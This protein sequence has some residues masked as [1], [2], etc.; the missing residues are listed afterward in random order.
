MS[1][2]ACSAAVERSVKKLKGI[3]RIEVSLLT[4]S[5]T[6]DYDP[7]AVTPGT[8][9]EAV[10]NAGYGATVVG[11][12]ETKK[13]PS[14]TDDGLRDMRVRLIASFAFLIPLMYVA[15]GHMLSLPI[16]PF[17]AGESNGVAFAL[18]QLLLTLPIMYLN[19]KYY[20]VGFR[21]LFKLSPNMDTLVATGSL[22]AILYGVYSIYAISYAVANNDSDT[23]SS[24]L[25]N[26]YFESGA[27]ILT[28][29]TLGKYFEARSKR[30]TSE[31]ISKLMALTPDKAT[32]VRDGTELEIPLAE[33]RIGDV[34]AVR[35]GEGIAA[36]GVIVQGHASVDE[37]ALTG[38]SIP[39]E[40][41]AG[42]KVSAGTV[43]G[44]GYFRF[45]VE[46]LGEDTA[47]S[48]ILRLVE[49]AASSKAPI[50]KL[51]DKVSGVFVPVVMI[52]SVLTFAIWAFGSGD[53]E[54][55]LSMAISVLVISC[56]CALGLATPT[57]IMVGTGR[58]AANGI[59][60]RNAE[61][62]ETAHKITTVVLDKTGTVTEGRPKVT[63]VVPINGEDADTLVS[64]AA[65]VEFPSE[66][67]LS[68]AIVEYAEEKGIK[69][70]PVET[71]ES[72]AGG[73]IK[74]T[75]DG[76]TFLAGNSRLMGENGI[77]VSSLADKASALAESGKTPLYFACDGHVCGIIA[78]ADTVKGTSR[79]AV[80]ALKQMGIEVIMLTGD[81]ERTGRNIA[82]QVG[83]EAVIA[84]VLPDG[85]EAVITELKRQGKTVAMVGD[86]INDAPALVSADVGI[87][88]GAGT[89][90]AIESADIVLMKSD[91]DDVAGAI[92]LSRAVIKNIKQ[93]LFWAFFYNTLGIPLAAGALYIPLGLKLS[94]MIGAACM[95][96]SS[97]CV[98]SNALRLRFFKYKR[99]TAEDCNSVCPI[100]SDKINANK[101]TSKMI[102]KTV[103]INGMMCGH[104]S[105]RVEEAL[106][107]LD[108]VSAKVNLRKKY[109]AVTL[110]ADVSDRVL[111]ETVE[112][113]GYKVVK[114]K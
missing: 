95:S 103:Y 114:I 70:T 44:S 13:M 37:S 102:E 10:K 16:P 66:H 88:I 97:V 73:G 22:A 71:I 8:V 21:A 19:R 33:L 6:V 98:V 77:D 9:I 3:N 101:E 111:T 15:M 25:H 89:D 42:D 90:I 65:G 64:L 80:E 2:S 105:A 23:L 49:E 28:L 93:N 24:L 108:G 110:T 69:Y 47:V 94:P 96:F 7:S 112:K 72:I 55:A 46:K 62:L 31:A 39:V 68:K 76:K 67:P 36:D 52:I 83:I 38:E 26:L 107:A 91:L 48:G 27:M 87:A 29:I 74:G 78:V 92:K 41:S 60:I 100:P 109:A 58:G 104:C 11:S 63:D 45:K 43:N 4:N 14:D 61:S 51:A 32:V 1:C 5:M 82:S 12:A 56:P 113:A 86:G 35:M 18:T 84:G 79:G 59:L 99:S 34:V 75:S 81:N 30:K 57:A 50:A 54:H 17:L 53:L 40:K 85:K 106:N 20:I